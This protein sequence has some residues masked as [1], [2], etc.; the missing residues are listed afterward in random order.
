MSIERVADVVVA[1]T[2]GPLIS[3][4]SDTARWMAAFRAAETARPD[5][6]FDDPFADTFAGDRG[7]AIAAATPRFL[8]SGWWWVIRTKLIDDLIAESIENGCDRV[9]NL[10]TGFDTRPY[11]LDLPTGLEWIEADLPEIVNEKQGLLTVDTARCQLSRVAV[12]LADPRSRAAFLADAT[13]GARNAVV[14]TEGLLLYLSRQQVGDLADDLRRNE[15]SEW[16]TDLLAPVIVRG[17]MRRIPSLDKAPM[18]F[19]PADGVAFF[20]Q[21]EWSVGT[22]RTIHRYAGLW[23][24]MPTVLRPAA[25]IPDPNPRKL[26]HLP[27]SAVVRF[28]R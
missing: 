23:K 10:A 8:R 27:W 5:A 22:I 6:L 2:S 1:E 11:R 7:R 18:T 14:I 4:V 12:D 13:S 16:I 17:M 9:L 28:D 21:R 24:R 26:A 3:N 19:E 20:E 15:I 25:H